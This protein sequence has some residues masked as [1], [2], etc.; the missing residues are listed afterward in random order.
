MLKNKFIQDLNNIK[1]TIT[2]NEDILKKSDIYLDDNI[3]I[4]NFRNEEKYGDGLIEYNF[5]FSLL[6]E[7]NIQ[8]KE[9]IF[10]IEYMNEI[11]TIKIN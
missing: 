6:N 5:D 10:I 9:N 8:F 3:F 7:N 4:A 2:I 11:Y 1:T